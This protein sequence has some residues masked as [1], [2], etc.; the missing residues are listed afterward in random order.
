MTAEVLEVEIAR[1]GSG[2]DGVA[3][4]SSG[5]IYVPFTLPGERVVITL[6]P[7]EDR[8]ALFS[9][10]SARAR[11]VLPRSAHISAI[12]AAARSSTW[13]RVPIW[14]GSANRSRSRS[15]HEVFSRPRSNRSGRCLW[16]AGGAPRFRS[17]EARTVPCSAIAAPALTS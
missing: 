16:P 15:N 4:S 8:G 12:A 11:T 10:C 14:P 2:G 5:P 6:K 1:L 17:V 7:G 3:E 9:T 13:R